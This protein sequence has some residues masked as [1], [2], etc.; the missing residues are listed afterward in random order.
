MANGRNRP[1]GALRRLRQ[2]R[3][4]ALPNALAETGFRLNPNIADTIRK[5]ADE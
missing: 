5:L 2:R 4:R 1:R 3:G